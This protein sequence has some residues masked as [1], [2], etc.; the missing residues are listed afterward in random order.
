MVENMPNFSL[1]KPRTPAKSKFDLNS[2]KLAQTKQKQKFE[3]NK[4]ET[5]EAL[6]TME[7]DISKENWKAAT[8]KIQEVSGL[9]KQLK[10][11]SIKSSLTTR[12]PENICNKLKKRLD[13][14][15][16]KI[17]KELSHV[18]FEDAVTKGTCLPTGEYIGLRPVLPTPV[19]G[20]SMDNS[21]IIPSAPQI[22]DFEETLDLKVRQIVD[23]IG[24][25]LSKNKEESKG[26]KI[27]KHRGLRFQRSK[28][29]LSKA[30]ENET[31][32][33]SKKIDMQLFK[34]TLRPYLRENE[35]MYDFKINFGENFLELSG[36]IGDQKFKYVKQEKPD[37]LIEGS[38]TEHSSL[39]N[40]FHLLQ[41]KKADI[42]AKESN[43]G[44][45]Y[46]TIRERE[47]NWEYQEKENQSF[48]VKGK[49]FVES[50]ERD[51]YTYELIHDKH[52]ATLGE[53][54]WVFDPNLKETKLTEGKMLK[55]YSP[56]DIEFEEKKQE[57]IP[58]LNRAEVVELKKIREFE[59][60]N[61]YAPFPKVYD[62]FE[63]TKKWAFDPES[64]DMK[65]EENTKSE[66]IRKFDKDIPEDWTKKYQRNWP[67]ISRDSN[68]KDF[69]LQKPKTALFSNI[70]FT[71]KYCPL[72]KTAPLK[73]TAHLRKT[74]PLKKTEDFDIELSAIG[75]AKP[76]QDRPITQI[77]Q[78]STIAMPELRPWTHQC[79]CSAIS[80]NGQCVALG[81]NDGS[82]RLL[83]VDLQVTKLLQE[84][85]KGMTEPV[86]SMEFSQNGELLTVE[87]RDGRINRFNLSTK[88]VECLL[89]AAPNNG[90]STP[91]RVFYFPK[92]ALSPD[93]K[94]IARSYTLP[95][96]DRDIFVEV[97]DKES[98]QV[99]NTLILDKPAKYL[100][101]FTFS[102]DSKSLAVAYDIRAVLWDFESNKADEL[103]RDKDYFNSFPAVKFSPNGKQVVVADYQNTYDFSM[104]DVDTKKL[105]LTGKNR[106][107]DCG[108]IRHINFSQDGGQ[109]M[110]GS[111]NG[112]F[113]F[114]EV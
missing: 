63:N 84:S 69:I 44:N 83:N 47:G 74:A 67:Y 56:T 40:G 72:E 2:E 8:L 68:T 79:S 95:K 88:T 86:S 93:G 4:T 12:N 103:C 64:K 111:Q 38:C 31:F 1:S 9:I 11:Y 36:I 105:I 23:Y 25:Q 100:N 34:D 70:Y 60:Y 30:P 61:P 76:T 33:L 106:D 57:F 89:E 102:P 91:E 52:Q 71:A 24:L 108:E 10:N 110:T 75:Q 49:L 14:A 22:P 77:K 62:A 54:T 97:L 65:A 28:N 48:L 20:E 37:L 15:I 99:Q 73:K 39:I 26:E 3:L 85:I 107:R 35:N 41:G 16:S 104:Y 42:I 43:L 78:L 21:L 59:S 18:I 81:S 27:S 32:D 112:T 114:Y 17:P 98:K 5:L 53:G 58:E 101:E 13:L 66:H 7:H 55:I 90:K 50:E 87:H 94:F 109:L 19:F 46:Y 113:K 45:R 92:E 96:N 82:L 29:T 80:P 51:R 6:T